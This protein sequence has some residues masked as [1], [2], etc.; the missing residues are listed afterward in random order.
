M[1][2][3]LLSS[4]LDFWLGDGQVLGDHDLLADLELLCY[5]DLLRPYCWLF[6]HH[7]ACLAAGLLHCTGAGSGSELLTLQLSENTSQLVSGADQHLVPLG[8]HRPCRQAASIGCLGRVAV[9]HCLAALLG[10]RYSELE[11]RGEQLVR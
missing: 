6:L 4:S 5:L 3:P 11:A 7:H 10:S 9:R 8:P 1:V 2:L